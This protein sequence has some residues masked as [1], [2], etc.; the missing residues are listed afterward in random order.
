MICMGLGDDIALPLKKKM[1]SYA[2]VVAL[3]F[4]SKL[5]KSGGADAGTA[6]SARTKHF[7]KALIAIHA[8]PKLLP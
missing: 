6:H 8:P 7:N 3:L 5:P 1:Q 2:C 4:H